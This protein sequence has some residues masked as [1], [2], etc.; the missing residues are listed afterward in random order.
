[1][2]FNPVFG[3]KP[4][5]ATQARMQAAP[6]YQDGKFVNLEPTPS[7]VLKD[8]NGNEIK[9]LQEQEFIWLGHSTI[10]G[11]LNGQTFLTDPVFYSA[12]PVSFVGG[13]PYPYEYQTT[14]KDIPAIDVVV[15]SHDHYDH[16]EMRTIK[17]IKDRVGHFVVPLG[18][19]AHLVRWG[20]DE[21]KI[22]ELYWHE[23]VTLNGVT[24]T[25]TPNRHFS[26]R[27]L[28][29]QNATLWGSYVI[30]TPDF[31]L[32]FSGDGGYGKH[33]AQIGQE[34]GPFD[35][36]FIENGEYNEKWPNIHMFPHQS[37]QAAKDIN[38][39][40]VVPIHWA[41]FDLSEHTWREPMDVYFSH[42]EQVNPTLQVGTPVIGTTFS[43]KALPTTH[44]WESLQ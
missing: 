1:M 33:F 40:K 3:G 29:G 28:G 12:S 18:V 6:N 42:K 7:L 20:V 9:G 14:S 10:V 2:Q 39:P 19:K 4:D 41:K 37:L 15:L 31:K 26:G 27:S 34:Y 5:A 35:A 25:L 11:K 8:E 30:T 21:S 43:F 24:Y 13:K 22:T 36:A 44:W 16:L 23:H 17:E 32:F 38:T